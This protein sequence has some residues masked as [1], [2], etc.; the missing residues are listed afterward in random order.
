MTNNF[1][2]EIIGQHK[3]LVDKRK[4]VEERPNLEVI[5][6]VLVQWNWEDNKDHQKSEV[7]YT[8]T[9][10]ESYA[11]MLN[12]EPSNSVF[13]ATYWIWWHPNNI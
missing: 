6:L 5:K 2:R 9:P 4:N 8:F 3:I 1:I 10:N 11:Y 12:V 7:V 13:L